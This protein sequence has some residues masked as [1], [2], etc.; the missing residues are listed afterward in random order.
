MLTAVGITS[1]VISLSL[2][3]LRAYH[4]ERETPPSG[5]LLKLLRINYTPEGECDVNTMS[6][7]LLDDTS[8]LGHN[9]IVRNS[10]QVNNSSQVKNI[11]LYFKHIY[12]I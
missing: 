2:Y 8:N 1:L 10:M 4:S 12:K 3:V 9:G 5:Y 11:H 7:T 6:A